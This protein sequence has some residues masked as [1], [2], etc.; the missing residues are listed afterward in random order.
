MAPMFRMPIPMEFPYPCSRGLEISSS[1]SQLFPQL[2]SQT[3][4]RMKVYSL[5]PNLQLPANWSLLVI[6]A[7]PVS[8]KAEKLSESLPDICYVMIKHMRYLQQKYTC[9]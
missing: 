4:K 8:L 9:Q 3:I 6:L 5:L 2:T 1:S 7:H